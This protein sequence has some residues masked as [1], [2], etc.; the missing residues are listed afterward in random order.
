MPE[1]GVRLEPDRGE[2]WGLSFALPTERYLAIGGMD[3]AFVGYGGEE[4][5]FSARL[6]ETGL[7]VY[8]TAGARAYH[9][10]HTVRV[11]PLHEFGSILRNASLFHARHGRW[12]MTYWL[13]QFRDGGFIDW[14]EEGG[15]LR[16]LREPDAAEIAASGRSGDTLFS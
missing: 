5:D 16:V 7:K 9:Q 6:G 12:C 14:R 3:E 1:R 13:G 2:L 15:E 4:T 10:H 8:W 11:P